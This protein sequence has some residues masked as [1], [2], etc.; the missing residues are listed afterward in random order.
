[1]RPQHSN[2]VFEIELDFVEKDAYIFT[3]W[4][5]QIMYI[6]Y[7]VTLQCFYKIIKRSYT[8]LVK[9]QFQSRIKKK[10]VKK[11]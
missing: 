6:T 8:I 2:I 10:P 9:D 3:F 5:I 4:Q 1:M 11:H 7:N